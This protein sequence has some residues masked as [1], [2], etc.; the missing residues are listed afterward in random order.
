MYQNIMK[1][2]IIIKQYSFVSSSSAYPNT[3]TA[4]GTL[5][6]STD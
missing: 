2:L 4:S 5:N 3:N 1:I 6:A